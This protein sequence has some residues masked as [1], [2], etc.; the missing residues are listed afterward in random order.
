MIGYCKR[1]GLDFTR[2]RSYHKNDQA[3]VEERNG[4]L[5]RKVIGYDRIEDDKIVELIANIYA[6]ELRLLSNY[7]WP[8]RK[9]VYKEKIK[10]KYIKRYDN[11]RTPYVRVM[12]SEDVSGDVKCTL[13][14]KYMT[15]NPMALTRS[16]DKKLIKLKKLLR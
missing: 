10:G 1:E 9:L 2:S 11:A 15:L 16:L 12:E 4:H 5:V 13:V 7:F 6:N 3:H 14:Q 8:V